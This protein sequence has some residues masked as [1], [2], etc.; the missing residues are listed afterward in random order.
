MPKREQDPILSRLAGLLL[1]QF[2]VGPSWLYDEQREVH[3]A[4]KF[5]LDAPDRHSVL[6]T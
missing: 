5:S 4:S 2:N 6:S 3:G 1:L